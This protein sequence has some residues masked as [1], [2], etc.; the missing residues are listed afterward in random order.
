VNEVDAERDRATPAQETRSEKQIKCKVSSS[1]HDCIRRTSPCQCDPRVP[2]SCTLTRVVSL[3]SS[4]EKACAYDPAAI[5]RKS[6]RSFSTSC[7]TRSLL[8]I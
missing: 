7:E 8:Q 4:H 3:L 6:S 2:S 1:R 5:P